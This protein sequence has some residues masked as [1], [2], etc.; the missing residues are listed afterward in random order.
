MVPSVKAI[1]EKWPIF[2]G[3]IRVQVLGDGA[4]PSGLQA[5]VDAAGSK[6]W[7]EGEALV[8]LCKQRS[9]EGEA[10]VTPLGR[11]WNLS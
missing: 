4:L 9:E 5:I 11:F 2:S 6:S 7:I 10:V 8:D 3:R 1:R